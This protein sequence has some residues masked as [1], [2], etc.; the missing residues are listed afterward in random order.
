[1]QKAYELAQTLISASEKLVQTN[2]DR[3]GIKISKKL[4]KTPEISANGLFWQMIN[5]AWGKS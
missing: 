1:M 2:M 5:T 3:V 4:C